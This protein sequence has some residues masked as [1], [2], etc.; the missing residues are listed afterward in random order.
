MGR[1]GWEMP[2]PQQIRPHV[3]AS[4]HLHSG[5]S[6]TLIYSIISE[7]HICAR[8]RNTGGGGWGG[9]EPR[10][11]ERR[12]C[13]GALAGF[14]DL[15]GCSKR[16]TETLGAAQHTGHLSLR[17]SRGMQGSC[18]QKTPPRP[19]S[20]RAVKEQLGGPRLMLCRPAGGCGRGLDAA[21]RARWHNPRDSHGPFRMGT[22][23]SLSHMGALLL[24]PDTRSHPTWGSSVPLTSKYAFGVRQTDRTRT[25]KRVTRLGPRNRTP[26]T[27]C[28]GR[29]GRTGPVSQF[30]PR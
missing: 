26:R 15:S 29:G 4:G 28:A 9:C 24:P 14:A 21:P 10:V 12:G 20:L 16:P 5:F 30:L 17:P 18:W 13:C 23:G 1:T 7:H 2:L 19:D 22:R 3:R 27:P 6:K 25:G 8:E 11:C